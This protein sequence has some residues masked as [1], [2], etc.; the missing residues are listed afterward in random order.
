MYENFTISAYVMLAKVPL[1]KAITWP[2]PETVEETT[3][4]DEP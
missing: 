2:N 1:P 4:L 3:K